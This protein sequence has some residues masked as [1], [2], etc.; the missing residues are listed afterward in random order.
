[1]I[2]APPR[3]LTTIPT[4][5]WST[6]T[7]PFCR[8]HWSSIKII[9]A[10]AAA[11]W[12]ALT[13]DIHGHMVITWEYHG[14]YLNITCLGTN[15]RQILDTFDTTLEKMETTLVTRRL[16]ALTKVTFLG[17]ITS[18]CTNLDQI[19]ASESRPRFDFIISTIKSTSV[20]KYWSNFNFKILTTPQL[21]YLEQS[22]ASKSLPNCCQHV[23][24]HQH[25]QQ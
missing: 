15:W 24:L 14:Q 19:S 10:T 7:A 12:K 20:S 22:S 1:M 9:L 13:Q 11:R 6:S 8:S 25:Q 5:F 4:Y 18:F 23:P 2:F 21:R 16:S 17:H 3:A